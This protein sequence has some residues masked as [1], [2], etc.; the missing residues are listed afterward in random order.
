MHHCFLERPHPASAFKAPDAILA[1][2][3]FL[4][5]GNRLTCELPASRRMPP[6]LYSHKHPLSHSIKTRA[7]CSDIHIILMAP[8]QVANSRQLREMLVALFR[9]VH[10]PMRLAFR[11]TIY[12]IIILS[13]ISLAVVP[14]IVD[15]SQPKAH[16]MAGLMVIVAAVITFWSAGMTRRTTEENNVREHYREV[17]RHLRNRF[18]EISKLLGGK[19]FPGRLAAVYSLAA[20]ADEWYRHGQKID[21]EQLGWAERQVCINLLCAYLRSAE[22]GDNQREREVRDSAIEVIRER[23]KIARPSDAPNS[24]SN[25]KFNFSGADLTN[26]DFSR[27]A[28]LGSNLDMSDTELTRANFSRSALNGALFSGAVVED[29]KFIGTD[30][31]NADF[32]GVDLDKADTR[33][34]TL[35]DLVQ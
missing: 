23:V 28:F 35:V 31:T 12:S 22:L 29:A 32:T 9:K 6:R 16:Y 7:Q 14:L 33:E 24:W 11:V 25:H 26:A 15:L 30:L 34:A 2:K 1:C 13:L 3:D 5:L 21:D 4:F 8:T 18:S 19:S 17:E 20:L 10:L 27:C